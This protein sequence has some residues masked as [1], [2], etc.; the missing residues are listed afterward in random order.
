MTVNYTCIERVKT[1]HKSLIHFSTLYSTSVNQ[2]YL[3]RRYW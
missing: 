2:G 1:V 3:S